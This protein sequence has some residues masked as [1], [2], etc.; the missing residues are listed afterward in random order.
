MAEVNINNYHLTGNLSVD[1][2]AI[3]VYDFPVLSM[4]FGDVKNAR[5]ESDVND[6]QAKP[7][8]I[9]LGESTGV[10]GSIN[11]VSLLLASKIAGL[12]RRR[13]S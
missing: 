2:K 1:S 6:P 7:T 5:F 11:I 3:K 13:N 10:D 8:N 12:E 4:N 9:A